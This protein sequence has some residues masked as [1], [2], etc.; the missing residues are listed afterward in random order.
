M[1]YFASADAAVT[2]PAVPVMG[3]AREPTGAVRFG[4]GT[5][6]GGVVA[7]IVPCCG[8]GAVAVVVVCCDGGAR[9]GGGAAGS[10]G[11]ATDGA[12]APSADGVAPGVVPSGFWLGAGEDDVS[13]DK[14]TT[15][16][17]RLLFR[18]STVSF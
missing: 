17:R 6:A 15:T 16:T 7:A 2:L 12:V 8:V 9:L 4:A 11:A 5:A 10:P 18:P 13:V 1:R 14:M 3:V